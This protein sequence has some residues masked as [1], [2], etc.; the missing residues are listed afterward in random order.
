MFFHPLL[1]PIRD[2][3]RYLKA[4]DCY[5]SRSVDDLFDVHLDKISG[6]RKMV[7]KPI[8]ELAP[9]LATHPFNFKHFHKVLVGAV[10]EWSASRECL[11]TVDIAPQPEYCDHVFS[12]P[13]AS[14]EEPQARDEEGYAAS[15]ELSTDSHL[16][17]EVGTAPGEEVTPRRNDPVNPTLQG[18][19]TSLFGPSSRPAPHQSP[20]RLFPST[21]SKDR[22][23]TKRRTRKDFSPEQRRSILAL[24]SKNY[25][26]HPN[27]VHREISIQAGGEIDPRTCIRTACRRYLQGNF[28]DEEFG[29]GSSDIMKK[30]DEAGMVAKFIPAP[31]RNN[32]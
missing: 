16:A 4:A 8:E 21:S 2:N 32:L 30:M 10:N 27:S 9:L 14:V 5:L 18:T 28:N 17:G 7:M 26:L 25:M 6:K 23:A 15:N 31:A 11:Q 12:P 1:P 24:W 13:Q 3:I 20:K 29:E 19:L 22:F